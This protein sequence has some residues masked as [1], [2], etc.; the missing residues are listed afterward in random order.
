MASKLMNS[1]FS[2]Y[3]SVYQYYISLPHRTVPLIFIRRGGFVYAQ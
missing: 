1:L 2:K 3:Q